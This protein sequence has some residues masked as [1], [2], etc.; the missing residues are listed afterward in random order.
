MLIASN[1]GVT[2][3]ALCRTLGMKRANMTPLIA[4]LEGRG[5]VSKYPVDR[6]SHGLE[7]TKAGKALHLSAGKIIH[8]YEGELIA[9]VPDVLRSSVI[10]ILTALWKGEPS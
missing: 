4:K 7:L 3:S 1:P 6:R 2:Q 10:P 8:S 9:R 5:V